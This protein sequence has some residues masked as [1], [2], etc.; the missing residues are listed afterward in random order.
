MSHIDTEWN[1][2][3]VSIRRWVKQEMVSVAD[4]WKAAGSRSSM[5]PD[6]WFKSD[7]IQEQL[8]SLAILVSEGVERDTK[9]KLIKVPGILEVVRGGRYTQGTFASY[10]LAISYTQLLGQDVWE[11]FTSVLPSSQQNESEPQASTHRLIPVDLEDFGGK[12]RFTPDGRISVYDSIA[13]STGHKN[14]YQVWN[15]LTQRFPV[16]LQKT[17]EYKFEGRGGQAR[18]T[19][20][21]TLQVFVE[22]LV[23]L[24]GKLANTVREEAVRTLIRAM[25]GDPTLVE[26][27]VARIR[28]PQDLK[29]LEELIKARRIKAYG[30]NESPSGTLGN[31]LIS[32]DITSEVK[33]GYGWQNKTED[34]ASLLVDLATH[35]GDM[36]IEKESPHRPYDS[37]SKSKS[38]MI[39]LIIR[40]L[41]NLE[42]L[43][44]YMFESNYIDDSDVVEVFGKRAYPELAYRD[45]VQ[46]GVKFVVA[47]L[48][49]PAGITVAGV[50]RLQEIQKTLDEK[51]QGAIILD[52]MRL[53][54]LVWG[55]MYPAIEERYSDASGKFGWHYLN[56]KVKKIC[57]SL[58][59]KITSNKTLSSSSESKFE[60]L[61]LF[62]EL[63]SMVK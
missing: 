50:E 2:R 32:T 22:I 14:P 63:L 44:I 47:H 26:E 33:K 16:F 19:P 23:T 58:C 30:N 4:L 1:F 43:H 54:E 34:M 8:E 61:S 37:G 17:E 20:V 6:R 36:V 35:V 7:L 62:G 12:V 55:E 60:Q 42:T 21:A 5:R 10:D 13:F 11:W 38:R 57:T 39:P 56:R 48:V 15:D 27:I 45:F 52:A 41:K 3:D 9:G 53:D 31:P 18:P 46:K 28:N 51:Y 24:P 25:N 49:S 29:D 40:T 59:E